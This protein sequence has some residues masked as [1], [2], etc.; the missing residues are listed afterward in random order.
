MEDPYINIIS[1]N[2]LIPRIGK[3]EIFFLLSIICNYV[4]SVRRYPSSSWSLG[5]IEDITRVVIS[6]EVYQ[7]SLRRNEMTTSVIFCLS[8]DL[9]KELLF[10][11]KVNIISTKNALLSR[12]SS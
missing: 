1:F 9:S 2:G 8:F 12:T 6:Y 3:R 4:V 10:A 5:Y 11:F 7:T